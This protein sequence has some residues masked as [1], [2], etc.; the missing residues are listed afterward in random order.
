MPPNTVIAA[1]TLCLTLSGCGA[2]VGDGRTCV[3]RATGEQVVAHQTFGVRALVYSDRNGIDRFITSETSDE[4]ECS[5][6][7][8]RLNAQVQS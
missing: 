7:S 1:L 3:N 8:A 2:P 6:P 4:W 5:T